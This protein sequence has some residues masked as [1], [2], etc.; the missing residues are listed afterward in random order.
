VKNW[1]TEWGVAAL[2]GLGAVVLTALALK[3]FIRPR[4]TA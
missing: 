3:A 4:T 1:G 2:A